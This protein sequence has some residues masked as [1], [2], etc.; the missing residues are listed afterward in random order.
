MDSEIIGLQ[1]ALNLYPLHL[2]AQADS[3]LRVRK[4]LQSAYGSDCGNC[5]NGANLP[6]SQAGRRQANVTEHTVLQCFFWSCGGGGGK[7]TVGDVY[8]TR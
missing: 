7:D 1:E 5:R 4:V 2:E 8:S 3:A 6:G